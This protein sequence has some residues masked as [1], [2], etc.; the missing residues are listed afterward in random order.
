MSI[1]LNYKNL[2]SLIIKHLNLS[3]LKN[4]FLTNKY[5]HALLKNIVSRSFEHIIQTLT[6]TSLLFVWQN[7]WLETPGDS[8][9]FF[10]PHFAIHRGYNKNI[11]GPRT[12]F[13]IYGVKLH[14][15]HGVFKQEDTTLDFESCGLCSLTQMFRD[16]Y[17]P[18][19]CAVRKY[20]FHN[21]LC[22][23]CGLQMRDQH[24]YYPC[25][26]N[27]CRICDESCYCKKYEHVPATGCDCIEPYFEH[28]GCA[29]E[30][31]INEY[32]YKSEK[33]FYGGDDRYSHCIQV[34]TKGTSAKKIRIYK[35]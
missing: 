13:T 35:V 24:D 30:C 16:Q 7:D 19:Y 25:R 17:D 33:Y 20:W 26:N 3:D 21:Y 2:D 15:I 34:L 5:Y 9:F 32:E 29:K 11:F 10:I 8:T 6:T 18:N 1:F 4:L 12:F 31:I 22:S 28:P 23:T 27:I 14:K